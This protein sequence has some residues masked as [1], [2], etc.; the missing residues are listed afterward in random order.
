MGKVINIFISPEA[1]KHMQSMKSVE[2]IKGQGIKGDRY[3]SKKGTFSRPEL[4]P[5]QHVTLIETENCKL[6]EDFYK[7]KFSAECSRRNIET[8]GI[9][10]NDLIDKKVRVGSAILKG[11][12]LCEPCEHLAN[13]VGRQVLHGLVHRGGLRAEVIQGG[14]ISIDDEII[15]LD[16]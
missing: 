8:E 13:L 11:I 9:Q 10:L 7:M 15:E 16:K 2:L 14:I 3:F 1:G 4:N 12:R 5:G 6:I